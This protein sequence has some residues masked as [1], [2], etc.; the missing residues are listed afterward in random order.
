MTGRFRFSNRLKSCFD[1]VVWIRLLMIQINR[2][3]IRR[4]HYWPTTISVFNWLWRRRCKCSKKLHIWQFRKQVSCKNFVVV[5]KKQRGPLSDNIDVFF[6]FVDLCDEFFRWR[7]T[8][9]RIKNIPECEFDEAPESDSK[10]R[11][12]HFLSDEVYRQ[13]RQSHVPRGLRFP[14]QS[15]R[16]L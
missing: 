4:Y 7:L 1:V 13:N 6:S 14:Q 9:N 8:Q 12:T 15:V 2:K 3:Q 5:V 16:Q 11:R 10:C